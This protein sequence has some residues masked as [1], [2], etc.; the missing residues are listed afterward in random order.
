MYSELPEEDKQLQVT[1]IG[2]TLRTL[3]YKV[4]IESREIDFWEKEWYIEEDEYGATITDGGP[5]YKNARRKEREER[6]MRGVWNDEDRIRHFRL[7][8][9]S[10]I[11]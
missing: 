10:N 5:Q 7:F 8:P 1:L 3:G 2:N 9:K 11:E 4:E 6:K